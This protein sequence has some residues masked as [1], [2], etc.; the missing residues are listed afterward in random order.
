MSRKRRGVST[1]MDLETK[2][3][4]TLSGIYV[5]DR[6]SLNL[7]LACR[8]TESITESASFVV[9]Q[10]SSLWSTTT[11]ISPKGIALKCVLELGWKLP[12][13]EQVL[14]KNLLKASNNVSS[15]YREK[16]E[17]AKYDEC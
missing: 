11:P 12:L 6:N 13:L 15:N 17:R 8:G 10:L 9:C 1:K 2:F 4:Q 7:A 16:F 5:I 14:R 3:W